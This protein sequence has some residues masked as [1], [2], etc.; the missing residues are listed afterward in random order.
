MVRSN[1]GDRLV[2][3]GGLLEHLD[4]VAEL[5]AD[6]RRNIAWSSTITTLTLPASLIGL[7]LSRTGQVQVHLGASPGVDLTSPDPP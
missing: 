5:R 7:L 6:P 1:G 4:R 3:V 2:D